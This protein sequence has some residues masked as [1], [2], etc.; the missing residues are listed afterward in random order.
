VPDITKLIEEDHREVERLFEQFNTTGEERLA[1]QVCSEIE[2][3]AA[4][5]ES[6]FYPVVGTDVPD[7]RSLESEAEREHQ[8]ARQI[9]GR[10]K[11][12]KDPE[13]LAE[14]MDELEQ[15]I[16]HHVSEE[17]NE[18]LPKARETL[19]A[20]RLSELG[21]AFREAKGS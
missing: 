6:V 9:I 10:I 20:G 3:H 11:N 14:L 5:E 8:E 1:R 21:A 7:G 13:H 19:D 2:K 18:M 4:A 17:E 16:Q 12:T 15:A